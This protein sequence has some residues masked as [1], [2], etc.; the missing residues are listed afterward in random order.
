MW[1]EPKLSRK[2]KAA[3]RKKAARERNK[4]AKTA[5]FVRLKTINGDAFDEFNTEYTVKLKDRSNRDLGLWAFDTVNT[6]AWPGAAEHL[7]STA[8]DFT[9]VQEAKV[10]AA[11]VKDYETITKGFE[12][13]ASIG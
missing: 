1:Y 9:E 13:K 11:E 12:W 10:V 4:I 6:N 2:Q 5:G 8:A 3:A 7:A